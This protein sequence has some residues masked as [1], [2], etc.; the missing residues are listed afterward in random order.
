MQWTEPPDLTPQ[1]ISHY[2]VVISSGTRPGGAVVAN[3]SVRHS[4]SYT[5]VDL[6]G[7]AAYGAQFRAHNPRGWSQWSERFVTTLPTPTRA[8]RTPLT[9]TATVVDAS[10]DV[11][12]TIPPQLVDAATPQDAIQRAEECAGA[13]ALEVQGLLAGSTHWQPLHSLRAGASQ[14]MREL[15]PG[16]AYR[17]RLQASNRA[18]KSDPGSPTPIGSIAP[19]IP[20]LPAA[21]LRARPVVR[22]TSSASFVVDL[23]AVK[24]PCQAGL[25][26]VVLLHSTQQPQ[27]QPQPP[28][29]V[30]ADSAAEWQVLGSAPQGTSYAVEALRCPPSGCHFRLRPDVHLWDEQL[31]DGPVS[32]VRNLALPTHDWTLDARIEMRLYGTEWN[33]LLR[34]Q[35]RTEIASELGIDEP[36]VVEAHVS[37]VDVAVVLDL[38]ARQPGAAR[39]AAQRLA[40]LVVPGSQGDA[41]TAQTG[42]AMLRRVDRSTGIFEQSPDDGQWRP[43]APKAKLG[44]LAWVREEL[45]PRLITLGLWGLLALVITCAAGVAVVVLRLRPSRATV[46]YDAIAEQPPVDSKQDATLNGLAQ[47]LVPGRVGYRQGKDID[48]HE[49][50]GLVSH[51]DIE[52]EEEEEEDFDYEL[53]RQRLRE[54]EDGWPEQVVHQRRRIEDDDGWPT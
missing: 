23:P 48:G 24:A 32:T 18:G 26:W 37:A 28:G 13:E 6:F 33:S 49:S 30:A 45:K 41:T 31:L 20:G 40:A 27:Q 15:S 53:E 9:P 2:T 14:W 16:K 43:V 51:R 17:F 1:Q 36:E 21:T 25:R 29:L 11:L 54:D 39:D 35:L 5:A 44:L 38:K 3:A 42:G 46:A 7:A 19:V 12:M 34:H 8:P 52:E 50:I 22:A 10:C 4:T 47:G